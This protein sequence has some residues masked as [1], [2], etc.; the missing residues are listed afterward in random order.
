MRLV[1]VEDDDS[2]GEA[3]RDALDA[4]DYEVE[5]FTSADAATPALEDS[6]PDLVILDVGLPDVD[7]FTLCRWLRGLHPELPIL[8]VTARD[9]DIDVVVGLDSG[10]TDYVTKP[11]S[12]NVLLARVRAH[13]R[14]TEAARAD[15]PIDLG[16]VVVDPAA[17]RVKLDG[18]EVQLRT[19]EFELL[20]ALARA[21]GRVMTREQLLSDVWGLHWDTSSKSLEMHVV[22][23][24]RRFGDALALATVRGVGYRLDES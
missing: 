13:L 22:A 16:R 21:R 6:E 10:A 7:G 24:R 18:K 5:W 20:A 8:L 3:M 11:F 15:A 23:L 12:M 14:S 2:I 1:I 19:R 9:S 17:Y 4:A